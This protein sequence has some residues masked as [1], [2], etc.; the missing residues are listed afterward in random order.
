MVVEH[1]GDSPGDSYRP[2]SARLLQ[3]VYDEANK[4]ESTLPWLGDIPRRIY[5][6]CGDPLKCS[7]GG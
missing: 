5:G 3:G 6:P 1:P 7:E 2:R 4:R